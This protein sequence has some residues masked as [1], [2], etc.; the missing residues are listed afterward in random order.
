MTDDKQ[1][2]TFFTITKTESQPYELT[3]IKKKQH[4]KMY[5]IMYSRP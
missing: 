4:I 5:L 3:N 2:P 1:Q